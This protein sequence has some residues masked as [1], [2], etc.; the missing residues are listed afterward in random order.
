MFYSNLQV[1]RLQY[2]DWVERDESTRNG[3]VCIVI[4]ILLPYIRIIIIIFILIVISIIISIFTDIYT[5][6]TIFIF[7]I[8]A[9]GA[10][11]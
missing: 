11:V 5:T 9:L 10:C 4:I 1:N 6:T 7:L 8:T 3:L 2:C